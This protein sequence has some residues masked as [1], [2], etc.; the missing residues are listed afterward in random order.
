M[1]NMNNISCL[2]S[3]DVSF[4]SNNIIFAKEIQYGE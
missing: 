4:A 3:L 2:Y 1:I